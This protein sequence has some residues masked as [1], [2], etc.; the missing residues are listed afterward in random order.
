MKKLVIVFI[1]IMVI[2]FLSISYMVYVDRKD[3]NNLN[4]II[5]KKTNIKKYNYVNKYDNYYIVLTDDYLY[6]YD[7]SFLEL[8][9]VDTALIY[10]NKKKYDIIYDGKQLMY[11]HEY[12]YK[13]NNIYEYYNLYTYELIDK[14]VLGG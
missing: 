1:C 8:L 14:I 5:V 12:M 6:L 3:I 10:E 2:I 9:K 13:N 11:F 4:N 7:N